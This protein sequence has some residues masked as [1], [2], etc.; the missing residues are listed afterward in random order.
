LVNAWLIKAA[1]HRGAEI[2]TG[3]ANGACQA[4]GRTDWLRVLM[5]L[6]HGLKR[7]A[8]PFDVKS[9]LYAIKRSN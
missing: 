7:P 8:R 3:D 6:L 9:G 4:D 2:E 1:T 5:H